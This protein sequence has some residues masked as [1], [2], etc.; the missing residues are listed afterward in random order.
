MLTTYKEQSLA[1]DAEYREALAELRVEYER[2]R[3]AALKRYREARQLLGNR[4][5]VSVQRNEA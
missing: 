5:V 1:L 3:A 2:K 4:P